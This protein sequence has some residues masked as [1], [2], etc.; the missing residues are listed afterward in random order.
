MQ[1]LFGLATAI[2]H[3]HF[4]LVLPVS[5]EQAKP[6]EMGEIYNIPQG[7][8]EVTDTG[9]KGNACAGSNYSLGKL[10]V[11]G[12]SSQQVQ[13]KVNSAENNEVK[14]KPI[15]PNGQQSIS[16]LLSTATTELYIGGELSITKN[17]TEGIKSIHY[18]IEVNY[19]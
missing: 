15:L 19:Q 18:T 1:R 17:A 12:N 3:A 9:Y 11:N 16:I 5:I 14:F 10:I 13:I 2:A 7:V 8:C 4:N 6:L